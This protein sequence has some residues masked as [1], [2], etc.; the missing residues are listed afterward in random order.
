MQRT[1][2][3]VTQGLEKTAAAPLSGK[4]NGLSIGGA[5][6]ALAFLTSEIA[7]DVGDVIKQRYIAEKNP[8]WEARGKYN[9]M[10]DQGNMY[11]GQRALESMYNT[12]FE[13]P[14]TLAGA[15]TQTIG[16]RIGNLMAPQEHVVPANILKTLG[17]AP[18][19]Q[20]LGDKQAKELIRQVSS[21]APTVINRVPMSILPILQN[22]IDSGSMTIR[23]EM[24]KSLSDVEK[25]LNS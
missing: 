1:T 25:S 8:A 12:A 22:S 3:I 18:E 5:A 21:V 10:T 17:S 13:A 23:P 11:R 2:D 20:A 19:V 24:L 7:D 14:E 6:L 16:R 9:L 4:I 15:A